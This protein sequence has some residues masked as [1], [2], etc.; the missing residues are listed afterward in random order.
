MRTADKHI[1]KLTWLAGAMATI[2]G[3]TLAI[4]AIASASGVSRA[5]LANNH[6]AGLERLGPVVHAD[7]AMMLKV[8]VVLGIHDQA[9]LD[10]LL[11][12]QQNSSSRE[13]HRWLTPAQFARRFG[14]TPAQTNAVAQ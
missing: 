11:A 2:V 5:K 10:Q 6:P 3:W 1:P 14:P 7:P 13:Y 9:K 12:D 8:T 4:G